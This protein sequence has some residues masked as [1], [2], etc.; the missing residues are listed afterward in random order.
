[1]PLCIS[2]GT[3]GIEGDLFPSP[4]WGEGGDEGGF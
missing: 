3:T 2:I 4:R 1:V